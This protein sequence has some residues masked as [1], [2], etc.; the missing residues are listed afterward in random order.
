MLMYAAK[1]Q[2]CHNILKA[3]FIQTYVF[4]GSSCFV[5]VLAPA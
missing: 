5:T 4:I 1:L 2:A 3:C